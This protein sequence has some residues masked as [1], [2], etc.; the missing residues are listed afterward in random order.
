MLHKCIYICRQHALQNKNKLINWHNSKPY[1]P[2]SWILIRWCNVCLIV[3]TDLLGD[4]HIRLI[5]YQLHAL[6]LNCWCN[7]GFCFVFKNALVFIIHLKL[8][9]KN[10][11]NTPTKV[12]LLVLLWNSVTLEHF[13]FYL[14]AICIYSYFELALL[15]CFLFYI[16]YS[17]FSIILFYYCYVL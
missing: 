10:V 12:Y 5:V 8:G 14:Y 2:V 13:Y 4:N 17:V 9:G 16:F 7:S 11:Y 3:V 15:Y 1:Q 6:S